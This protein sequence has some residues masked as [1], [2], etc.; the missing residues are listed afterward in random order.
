MVFENTDPTE[1]LET[2]SF[3]ELTGVLLDP[4]RRR[5]D[6]LRETISELSKSI[7]QEEGLRDRLPTLQ[8]ERERLSRQ[9][10]EGR[11]SL[12]A[13]IPKG[14]QA[15]AERSWEGGAGL[16]DSSESGGRTEKGS[17]NPFKTWQE[18]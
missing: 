3:G 2:D 11:K 4:A 14:K 16:H 17:N 8:S 18:K 10:T 6:E 9:I 1:R 5:R 7:T 15:R 12:A 13:L